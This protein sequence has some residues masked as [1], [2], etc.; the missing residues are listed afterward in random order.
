MKLLAASDRVILYDDGLPIGNR[1]SLTVTVVLPA[2][3]EWAPGRGGVV[4]RGHRLSVTHVR[5][6]IDKVGSVGQ[7]AGSFGVDEKSANLCNFIL[8]P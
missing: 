7:Y 6:Y 2:E 4:I 3:L 1:A 5:Q 8:E